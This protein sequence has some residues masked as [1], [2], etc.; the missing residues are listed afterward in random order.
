[1]TLSFNK[2]IVVGRLTKDPK[3]S[4]F[5]NGKKKVVIRMAVNR[6]WGKKNENNGKKKEETLYIN[7]EAWEDKAENMNS[8]LKQGSPILV[9][10]YLYNNDWTNE[11]GEDVKEIRIKIEKWEFM[12]TKKGQENSNSISESAEEC[13]AEETTP[14]DFDALVE[15]A[16]NGN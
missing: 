8:F 7:C 2:V 10:G 9:E 12:E 6:T 16:V 3:F 13:V 15:Q 1:M 4:N 5:D 14:E 11:K